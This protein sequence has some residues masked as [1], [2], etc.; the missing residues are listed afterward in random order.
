MHTNTAC[1]R[2]FILCFGIAL[3]ICVLSGC[4]VATAG[5]FGPSFS[6]A[7]DDPNKFSAAELEKLRS[8]RVYS[9]EAGLQVTAR[10]SVEGLACRRRADFATKSILWDP[11]MSDITGRTPEEVAMTQLRWSAAKSGANAV[12]APTCTHHGYQG[13][14]GCVESW[15]CAGTA[16][17]VN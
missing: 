13:T 7:I 5:A 17:Q 15:V 14:L 12:V 2:F 6:R 11:D 3:G 1:Q 10:N 8:V 16:V 4:A 9:S